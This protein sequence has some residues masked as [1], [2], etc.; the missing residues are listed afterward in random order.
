MKTTIFKWIIGTGLVFITAGII[1]NTYFI[2][3]P[4]ADAT[5]EVFLAFKESQSIAS[6]FVLTGMIAFTVG[7]LGQMWKRKKMKK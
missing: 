6:S 7:L 4:A 1:Y 2:I 5:K 3:T